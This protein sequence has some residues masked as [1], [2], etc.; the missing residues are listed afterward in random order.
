MAESTAVLDAPG[1][2]ADTESTP[3]ESVIEEEAAPE[4]E[5]EEQASEEEPDVLTKEEYK[6]RLAD[7]R[8]VLNEAHQKA[9][10]AK[11]EELA[12]KEQA[13]VDKAE[14]ETYERQR[15]YAVD[16]FRGQAANLLYSRLAPVAQSLSAALRE[17]IK[18][19]GDGDHAFN[20]QRLH[21]EV[22]EVAKQL[23]PGLMLSTFEAVSGALSK[24]LKVPDSAKAEMERALRKQDPATIVQALAKAIREPLYAE[25]MAEAEKALATKAEERKKS[26][27]LQK[28]A[29]ERSKQDQPT[30]VSGRSG[31]L[32][33]THLTN[34][35]IEEMPAAEWNRLSQAQRDQILNNPKRWG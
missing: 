20:P 21:Y 25:A 22:N 30:G 26:A 28:T 34:K 1:T 15:G 23:T 13:A 6:K 2:G 24:E 7:Q 10:A 9:L 33:S 27:D 19:G 14:Q 11:E 35:Q 16:L 12:A 4:S 32:G 17:D 3:P 18:N 5:V 8:R 29:E 31:S